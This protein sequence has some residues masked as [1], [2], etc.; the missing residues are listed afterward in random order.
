M[1]DSGYNPRTATGNSTYNRAAVQW[2][3]EVMC[4]VLI[5]VLA[6]NFRLRDHQILVA[7]KCW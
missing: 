3:N 1:F 5:S 4:F 2:L 7:E 6:Y